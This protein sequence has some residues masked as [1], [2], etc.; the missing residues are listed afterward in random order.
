L[1]S[2]LDAPAGPASGPEQA[3]GAMIG[4]LMLGITAMI[5]ALAIGFVFSS[6]TIIYALMRKKVDQTPIEKI[7]V[8][9]EQR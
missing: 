1:F 8:H 9:L 5:A 7:W 4:L 3:V 2:L 6:M